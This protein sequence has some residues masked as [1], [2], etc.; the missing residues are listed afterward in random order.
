MRKK[1]SMLTSTIA[2]YL[3]GVTSAL[4]IIHLGYYLVGASVYDV[5]QRRR[6][7]RL[8]KQRETTYAP[9]VTV[10]IPAHNEEKVII[11]CIESVLASTYRDID[12]IVVNDASTDMTRRL[13]TLFKRLNPGTPLRVI[14]KRINGG[15]GRGLNDALRRYVK[16]ELVMMLDADSI[17]SPKAIEHAVTYFTDPTVS[18]VAAN[19]QIINQ[20]TLLS[21]LQK[22][23]HMVSYRSKKAYSISNCDFVIGGVAS[24]YRTS[25]I[26]SVGFYDTDTLTEDISLSLK[27]VAKGNRENR[28]LYGSDIMAKTEPVERV[29]ALF[30]QRFRWKYGSLQ[31]I[32]KHGDMMGSSDP[33]YTSMLTMYRLPMTIVTEA[34]LF[35]LPLTWAYAV[36]LTISENSLL[37][38]IGA[39][40]TI[41]TYMLITL[42]YDEHLRWRERLYLTLYVPIAYFIF[43]VMDV[44]QIIAVVKCLVKIRSLSN[45]KDVGSTWIS[46][47]RIGDHLTTISTAHAIKPI[48][49]IHE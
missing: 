41:S 38:L 25:V 7:Y 14:N 19:V 10:L 48:G 27:I 40:A 45:R 20:H 49:K 13:L 29:A 16:S 17:L 39:Y 36:Y 8:S 15:K 3:F 2:L 5:W 22:F 11:R 18:G 30:R 6:L 46:P 31:N 32:I 26:K 28:I 23:E 9:H 4:Y 21:I 37:L 24:T 33:R 44:I 47:S 43:Y 35:L 34:A 12:I 42:W 1:V